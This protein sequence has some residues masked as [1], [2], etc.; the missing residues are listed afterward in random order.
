MTPVQPIPS[1]SLLIV[2]D[3]SAACKVIVRMVAM[4]FPDCTLY[5]AE[6]GIQGVELFKRFNPDIIITDVNMPV[7]DG[8]EMVH[9]IR[10][11]SADATCIMVTAYSDKDILDEFKIIGV[12]AYLLKPLD[13]QDLFA[14]IKKCSL[15]IKQQVK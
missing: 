5:T 15:E 6:N 8:I 3:D 10:S 4:E 12:C 7:M 14:S 1:F 13:F 11:I 2:E 9:K